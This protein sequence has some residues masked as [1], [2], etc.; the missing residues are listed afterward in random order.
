M[1][2]FGLVVCFLIGWDRKGLGE[3][4]YSENEGVLI[5]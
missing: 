2:E 1:D 5:K 4:R 3:V